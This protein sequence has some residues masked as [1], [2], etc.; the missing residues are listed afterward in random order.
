MSMMEELSRLTQNSQSTLSNYLRDKIIAGTYP[1]SF[2][3]QLKDLDNIVEEVYQTNNLERWKSFYQNSSQSV[4][5]TMA[6]VQVNRNFEF[7]A[8]LTA[9]FNLFGRQV[10]DE[11]QRK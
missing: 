7:L 9:L 11:L 5:D 4:L 8:N 3:L 10:M 2:L 1:R 6:T